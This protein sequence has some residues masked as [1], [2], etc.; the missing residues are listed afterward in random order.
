MLAFRLS[1]LRP[2]D[3]ACLITLRHGHTAT[4]IAIDAFLSTYYTTLFVRPLLKGRW[5]DPRLR[6]L[7]VRSALAAGL[8]VGGAV[9]NLGVFAGHG[10]SELS[11]VCLTTCTLDTLWCAVVLCAL[12]GKRYENP[13]PAD[14]F[15]HAP[16]APPT[17]PT[18]HPA[19]FARP[20]FVT[21]HFSNKPTHASPAPALVGWGSFG[22]IEPVLGGQ[23]EPHGTASFAA[24]GAGGRRGSPAP[25]EMCL[26]AVNERKCVDGAWRA[27]TTSRREEVRGDGKEGE[28]GRVAFVLER[29]PNV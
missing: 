11:W 26:G 1:T 28:T 27:P 4:I 6:R 14:P 15:E 7:A 19:W 17:S 13:A 12:T 22:C 21:P 24:A 10:G 9:V 2:T 23:H 20:A 25:S 8:T 16:S 29:G 18:S 3:N 5:Q